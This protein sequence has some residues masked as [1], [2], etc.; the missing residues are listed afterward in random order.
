[1]AALIFAS[2]SGALLGFLRYNFNPASIFLG[3]S[4]SYFIGFVLA[5]LGLGTSQ[6]STVAVAI[7]IPV[8][9]LGLPLMDMV[10]AT[11]RR[12]IFGSD[13]FAPD[14]EHLHH[15]LLQL[16]Y[17]PRRAA[18]IFY[19]I[20]IGLGCFALILVNA[21][22]E[23][24][25]FIL[26]ALGI[27]A[28]IGIRKL[29]YLEYFTA[30]KIMG[31]FADI[32]DE[33]GVT[34]GRRTFLNRQVAISESENLYEFWGRV[35]YAAEKI[36]LTAITLHL[37]PESFG[38]CP[39]PILT[40]R[41]ETKGEAKNQEKKRCVFIELHLASNGKHY[42]TLRLEKCSELGNHDPFT[43]RRI[44]QLRRT[45]T[46]KLEQLAARSTTYPEILNDRRCA[47]SGKEDE[48]EGRQKRPKWNGRERRNFGVA[49][50]EKE[51]E[52]K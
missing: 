26:G 35:I 2:F 31:W 38:G 41:D 30:E 46:N 28:F 50:S 40:W 15:K 45:V 20:S 14:R 51:Q 43:L 1:L 22:D 16:G 11:F 25:A 6:K 18:L 4:G 36:K 34:R 9:A 48:M 37:S 12:F 17:T 27:I 21:R 10:I 32:T 39:L 47:L 42:G 49:L 13:I 7:L 3:D 44:E 23:R 52:K 24:V 8:V 29:G 5:A 19:G 33:A